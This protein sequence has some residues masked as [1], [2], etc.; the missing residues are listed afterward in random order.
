MQQ[1]VISKF[2]QDYKVE[3]LQNKLAELKNNEN[4]KFNIF[5]VLKLDNHEIRHSNF[6]AWLLN[7]NENHGCKTLFLKEFLKHSIPDID[8]DLYDFSDACI[9]TEYSTNLGRRID[10]LIYSPQNNFVCVIENKYGSEE[11]DEQC[12]HYKDFIENISC[13]KNFTHKYYIFLDINQPDKV[14]FEDTL[15]GYNAITYKEVYIILT[16]LLSND[17][18]NHDINIKNTIN[19]YTSILKEKYRMLDSEIKNLCQEIYSNYSETLEVLEQYK[20][21]FQQDIF[22]VMQ[23]VLSDSNVNITNADIKGNGYNN[24]TGCGIRFIPT[25]YKTN[26]DNIGNNKITKYKLFCSLEYYKEFKLTI[27]DENWKKYEQIN[28]KLDTYDIKAIKKQIEQNIQVI[29][30]YFKNILIINE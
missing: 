30:K 21:E 6:L 1:D 15:K 9:K 18:F 23:E 3:K 10:I 14:L 12:R 2:S 17:V 7:P 25:E 22:Q 19:Q 29:S 5:K 27:Y 28:W 8:I 24:K 11:H 26:K 4:A 16:K 13:F 20:Q